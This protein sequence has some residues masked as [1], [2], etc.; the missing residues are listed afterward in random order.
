MTTSASSAASYGS[1]RAITALRASPVRSMNGPHRTCPQMVAGRKTRLPKAWSKWPCVSTTTVTGNAG[2]LTKV[3]DD[4]A[5]LDVGGAGVDDE[6]LAV[7]EDDADVLV[8][9]R[10]APDEHAI[11]DL[12]PAIRDTHGRMVSTSHR[13]GTVA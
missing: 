5:G 6:R 11:A 12:D 9:E 3:G 1:S 10:V 8:V 13:G 2:Q 4:L 7:P